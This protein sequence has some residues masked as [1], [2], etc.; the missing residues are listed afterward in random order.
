MALER[1]EGIQ[2]IMNYGVMSTPE[3]VIDG[4]VVH[5][6]RVPA[7][8]KVEGCFRACPAVQDCRASATIDGGKRGCRSL[9]AH[10]H[11]CNRIQRKG[12]HHG[13]RYP[14]LQG[15]IRSTWL[16]KQ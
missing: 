11:P 1:V 12:V 6:D 3:V 13:N 4:T 16:A 14:R 9:S 7:R 10:R 2:R 15:P 8:S 5:T